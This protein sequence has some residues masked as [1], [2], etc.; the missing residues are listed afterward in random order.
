[1]NIGSNALP[2]APYEKHE[3]DLSWVKDIKD[4]GGVALFNDGVKS[5]GTAFD[6]AANGRAIKRIGVKVFDGTENFDKIG[7]SNEGFNAYSINPHLIN[8]RINYTDDSICNAKSSHY[9]FLPCGPKHYEA[10]EQQDATKLNTFCFWPKFQSYSLL[11]SFAT[12]EELKAHLAELYAAGTPLVVYYELAEPIEVEYD[13][14][15]LTYPVVAGGTEEAIA[16]E[17]STAF[18]ADIG[19]GIDAVKTILDLKARVEALEGK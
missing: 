18:R 12:E 9:S 8:E 1:M 14:K 11:V 10:C 17:P 3:L 13:E 7:W 19:Y 5:A 4:E 2:Y 16:S 6:E 15:N